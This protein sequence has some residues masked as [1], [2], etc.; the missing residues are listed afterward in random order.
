MVKMV[1]EEKEDDGRK[2]GT[3]RRAAASQPQTS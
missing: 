1:E 3:Y 2:D